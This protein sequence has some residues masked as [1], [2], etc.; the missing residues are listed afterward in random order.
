MKP[1]IWSILLGMTI[2]L[3]AC[4]SPAPETLPSAT[5]APVPVVNTAASDIVVA[6]AVAAPA[7]IAQLGFTISA[8][9][10]ETPVQEGDKVL[11]GQPLIVL[12]TTELE[13]AVAA[14]EAAFQSASVNAELQRGRV[15]FTFPK[16]G[17]YSYGGLPKELQLIAQAKAAQ[18]QAALETAKASLAS[19]TLLSPFDGT[20]VSVNVLPGE[21]VQTDQAVITLAG[22]DDLQIETTDLSERDISRVAIGQ[23]VIVYFQALDLTVTGKV[24]RISPRA[25]TLGGDVVYPVTIALDEQPSGLLW[26]MTAEVQIQ[27]K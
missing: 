18:A 5:P 10:K 22:L 14:A 2:M 6:S 21:L 19:G 13:F 11:A 9:V 15:K 8:L 27:T 1:F 16:N 20:V 7:Q 23:S 24:I 25:D 4:G 3:T 17:G 12:N 26:G